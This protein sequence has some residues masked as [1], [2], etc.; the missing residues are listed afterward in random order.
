MNGNWVINKSSRVSFCAVGADNALEHLNHSMKMSGGLVGITRNE[1]AR[2]KFFL[3]APEAK[4]MAAV[5]VHSAT[6]S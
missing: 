1:S 5:S 6:T 2:T 3:S 4:S